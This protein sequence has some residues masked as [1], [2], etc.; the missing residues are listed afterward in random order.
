MFC[1]SDKK[2]P[3]SVKNGK[4]SSRKYQPKFEERIPFC[5]NSYIFKNFHIFWYFKWSKKFKFAPFLSYAE[6]YF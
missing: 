6:I 5:L 2:S 4:N 1:L 3:N